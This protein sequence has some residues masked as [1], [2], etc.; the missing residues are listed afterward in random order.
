[1]IG[2]GM[3]RSVSECRLDKRQCIR[4]L[5]QTIPSVLKNRNL[6]YQMDNKQCRLLSWLQANARSL[7]VFKWHAF[8]NVT[9]VY[10]HITEVSYTLTHSFTATDLCTLYSATIQVLRS[11]VIVYSYITECYYTVFYLPFQLCFNRL[12]AL[13]PQIDSKKKI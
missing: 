12:W 10:S 3:Q 7:G 6:L 13:A 1:M 11:N 9:S 2:L 8:Y 5:I 4:S